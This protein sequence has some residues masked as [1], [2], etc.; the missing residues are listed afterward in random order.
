MT[1]SDAADRRLIDRFQLD[2]KRTGQVRR[3]LATTHNL[4]ADFFEHDLLPTVLRVP[5]IEDHSF[6]A[7][8]ELARR[9]SHCELVAVAMEASAYRG[10]PSLRTAVR[11]VSLHGQRLHAKLL[12][13]E[14]E[15]GVRLYTG[16]ANLTAAGFRSNREVAGL[17]ETL[18]DVPGDAADIVDVLHRAQAA[19][20]GLR[21]RGATDVLDGLA[22]VEE[23][24]RRWHSD[25]GRKHDLLWSGGGDSLADRV[26]ARWEESAT[27]ER[28]HIVSPFWSE[29]GGATSPLGSFLNKLRAD[30][31]LAGQCRVDL[32]MDAV[33][34]DGGG[35][36]VAYP[37]HFT[38]A[39]DEFSGV[40][41]TA[42]AVDPSVDAA[43]LDMKVELNRARLLH[44]KIVLLEGGGR[45]LGYAGSGNFTRKGW[46]FAGNANIE[47]GWILRGSA[48][49]LEALLPATVG[50]PQPIRV[51]EIFN[52]NAPTESEP[53]GFWPVYILDVEL[54]PDPDHADRLVLVVR[55]EADAPRFTISTVP[56]EGQPAVHLVDGGE[57]AG[58]EVRVPLD[59]AQLHQLLVDREVLVTDLASGNTANFPV[60]VAAGEARLR[61][62]IA[63]GAPRPG[64]AALIAYFQG[65]VAFEELYPE[66]GEEPVVPAVGPRT[67]HD[68][69]VDTSRILSYQYPGIRR[70]APGDPR[71]DPGRSAAR[72][73]HSN[74]R[75]SAR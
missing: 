47:L 48:A 53:E 18:E 65:K 41:V 55:A 6:K 60:N 40:S 70:S 63:P 16:S 14:Y 46:G 17:L 19:L 2:V 28:I 58:E 61:L 24:V 25:V 52:A 31:K 39:G 64:E 22:L 35:Y 72:A 21:E 12:V 34:L 44:A 15:F 57:G 67:L 30:S 71:G 33:R 75:F 20:G 5:N 11:P 73:P 32:Y 1:R 9:I 36:A 4:D 68:S 8:M 10:R 51:G 54:E 56:T 7:R 38:L 43:E 69:G 27:V 45:A 66:P 23:R 59:S 74:T 49:E 42:H 37:S 50:E 29:D 26:V 62:P 13:V 3:I